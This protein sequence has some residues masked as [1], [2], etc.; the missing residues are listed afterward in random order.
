M[1]MS[2]KASGLSSSSEVVTLV[3][4]SVG[5]VYDHG[6]VALLS[7]E[8]GMRIVAESL[9]VGQLEVALAQYCPHV[10]VLSCRYITSPLFLKRLAAIRPGIGFVVLASDR[11]SER[12]RK[13]LLALGAHAC[14]PEH[15]SL[16]DVLIAIRYAAS[17]KFLSIPAAPRHENESADG[18]LT[19]REAEVLRLIQDGLNNSQI[20]HDL[21]I[22]SETVNTHIKRIRRKLGVR[23]RTVLASTTQQS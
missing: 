2:V 4:G 19:T 15:S 1:S 9:E 12:W 21:Q 11:M 8:D 22:T 10:C 3:L 14:L 20:A 13:Q 17:G 6:L 23:R 18:L 16:E 5:P 7:K